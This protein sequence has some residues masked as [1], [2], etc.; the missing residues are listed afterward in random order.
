MKNIR[1][2]MVCPYGWDTPGGVQTHIRDLAEHLI[3]EGHFVSVL[4]PISDDSVKHED[5]EMLVNRF[6]FQLMVQLLEFCLVRL[7]ALEQN[8]GLQVVIL[9]F[10]ICMN[11]QSL[12]YLC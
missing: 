8:N 1:I 7:Q 6:P 9:I 4:T 5:Y 2:G 3:E 10:Y 12:H 11:R